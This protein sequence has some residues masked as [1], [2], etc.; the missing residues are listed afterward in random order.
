[1]HPAPPA[2]PHVAVYPPARFPEVAS[3]LQA[4]PQAQV[5]SDYCFIDEAFVGV[6]G[7][8]QFL[9]QGCGFARRGLREGLPIGPGKPRTYCYGIES[10]LPWCNPSRLA[11]VWEEQIRVRLVGARGRLLP[12]DIH[13]LKGGRDV[14]FLDIRRRRERSHT[15]RQT[16]MLAPPSCCALRGLR[17]YEP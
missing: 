12:G 8:G 7:N 14:D 17:R 10:S 5:P 16:T 9:W 15:S 13:A 3:Y 2:V 1:V 4:T 11:T 6:V